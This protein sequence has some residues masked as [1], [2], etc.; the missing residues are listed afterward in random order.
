MTLTDESE[1]CPVC[2]NKLNEHR[3][4]DFIDCIQKLFENNKGNRTE[5]NPT[6]MI[7][8]GN[9]KNQDLSKGVKIALS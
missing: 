1:I 3:V 4:Q 7:L 9:A 5:T 2:K 8:T 6:K